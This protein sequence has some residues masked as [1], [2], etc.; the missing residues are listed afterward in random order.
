M[1]QALSA[2]IS[3]IIQKYK[4]KRECIYLKLIII[5]GR[6][7]FFYI[8]THTFLFYNYILKLFMMLSPVKSYVLRYKF[9]IPSHSLKKEYKSMYV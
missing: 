6:I 5:Y 2:E 8:Y 1:Q 7:L 4:K 9:R 3:Y